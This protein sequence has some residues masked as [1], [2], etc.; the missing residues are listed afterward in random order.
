[1]IKI[2]K[3]KNRKLYNKTTHKYIKLSDILEYIKNNESVYIVDHLNVDV[4]IKTIFLALSG[5]KIDCSKQELFNFV[6]SL[7]I[8]QQDYNE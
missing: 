6:N 3:Y 7:M 5:S 2:K 1:M 4:T 8:L